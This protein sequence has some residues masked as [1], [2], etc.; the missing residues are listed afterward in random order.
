MGRAGLFFTDVPAACRRDLQAWLKKHGA[1]KTDAVKVVL[2]PAKSRKAV[3][4]H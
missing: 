4:A 2:E 1:R 3:A